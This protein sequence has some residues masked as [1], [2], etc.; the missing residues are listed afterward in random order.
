M[1]PSTSE[2]VVVLRVD[3]HADGRVVTVVSKGARVVMGVW[4][5]VNYDRGGLNDHCGW[6]VMVAMTV[7]VV[8]GRSRSSGHRGTCQIGRAHV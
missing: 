6:V 5:G 3:V 8:V 1:V 4:S 7:M 2:A